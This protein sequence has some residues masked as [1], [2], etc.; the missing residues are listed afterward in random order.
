MANRRQLPVCG[1]KAG[2]GTT[3]TVPKGPGR[4]KLVPRELAAMV[5]NSINR[6]KACDE[7]KIER[8]KLFKQFSEHPK[9]TRLALTIKIIDNQIADCAE[10]IRTKNTSAEI[11]KKNIAPGK[12]KSPEN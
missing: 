1:R 9:D 10:W 7:L 4:V 5:E 3:I 12:K 2:S 11:T 6:K 8:A